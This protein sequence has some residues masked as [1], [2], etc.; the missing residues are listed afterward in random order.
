ML[1]GAA[2]LTADSETA[3]FRAGLD[4]TKTEI[5]GEIARRIAQSAD[6]AGGGYW[7]GSSTANA[8]IHETKAGCMRGPRPP[9]TGSTS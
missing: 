5:I 6:A 3:R 7:W 9:S 8:A 2:S 1:F 4:T